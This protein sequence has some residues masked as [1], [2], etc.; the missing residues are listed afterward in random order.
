MQR[1]VSNPAI[2]CILISFLPAVPSRGDLREALKDGR[3]RR[4]RIKTISCKFEGTQTIE[5][6]A[7][8]G[9]PCLPRDAPSDVPAADHESRA[10]G[11]TWNR[12]DPS[13]VHVSA[14]REDVFEIEK[15]TTPDQG[16]TGTSE[17]VTSGS[18]NN[19]I[20]PVVP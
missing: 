17:S 6:G 20:R 1:Q 4:E 18:T 16:R 5:G 14:K 13:T 3:G 2:V 19:N 8:H 15:W 10:S 11:V 9:D 12:C 7:L